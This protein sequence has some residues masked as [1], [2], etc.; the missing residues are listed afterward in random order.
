[1]FAITTAHCFLQAV[2]YLPEMEEGQTLE[3]NDTSQP[4]R[5]DRVKWVTGQEKQSQL[6]QYLLR[7]L[8]YLMNRVSSKLPEYQIEGRTQV[9]FGSHPNSVRVVA[10]PCSMWRSLM[11]TE[12]SGVCSS[13][14]EWHQRSSTMLWM[15]SGVTQWLLCTC[16][17][18]IR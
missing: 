10:V 16:T 11:Y 17:S 5:L 7:N 4:Y 3:S 15:I 13:S 12:K 9:R 6:F 14:T 18:V 2:G 1:M 8:D